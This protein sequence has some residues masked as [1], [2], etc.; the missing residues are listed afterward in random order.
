MT[1]P[2]LLLK[3]Y[4]PALPTALRCRPWG[5][6]IDLS[7]SFHCCCD[8]QR[9]LQRSNPDIKAAV[10]IGFPQYTFAQALTLLDIKAAVFVAF[11]LPP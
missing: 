1:N 5:L 10:F 11:T 3:S 4:P 2:G 8:G 6:S 7:E 9:K